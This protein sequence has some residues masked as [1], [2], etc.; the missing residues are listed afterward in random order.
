MDG[1]YCCPARELAEAIE[2]RSVKGDLRGKRGS[3]A[4][5]IFSLCTPVMTYHVFNRGNNLLGTRQLG[6]LFEAEI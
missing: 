5:L 3:C 2:K 1:F 4:I 6:M